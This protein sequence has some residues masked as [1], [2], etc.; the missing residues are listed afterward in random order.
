METH[1]DIPN[2][3]G[4]VFLFHVSLNSQVAAPA[5]IDIIKANQIL[6]DGSTIVSSGGHFELGFVSVGSSTNQYVGIWYKKISQKTIVWIANRET[7]LSATSGLLKLNSN[8]NLVILNASDDVVWSSNSSTSL[9]DP[10]LQLLDS[11]NLVIRDGTDS[12]PDHFLW[13]SFDKPG[14]TQLP[15]AKIGWNFETGFERYLTSWKNEDDPSPGIYTNRVTRNGFPQ[16][17]VRKGSDIFTRG[18]SWNGVR[19]SGT[20]NFNPNQIFTSDFV[21]NDKELYYR[22]EVVNSSVVMRKIVNSFGYIQRL[23]WIEKTQT[24]QIY[25]SAPI[26]NCD[27]YGVCGAYGSCNVNDS[28]VCKCFNGF[29]PKDKK[30]WDATDW[31]SGCARKVPLSCANGEGFVKHSGLKLPDTQRSWFDTNMALMNVR[32]HA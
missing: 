10:V 16:L 7:P 26:D 4:N 3:D 20:P 25:F 9:N 8:G 27:R 28:P 5:A 11:G 22:Y 32:E 24:W 31:S 12:D 30:E 2:D 17:I 29:Q 15:G 21:S 23:V 13:Q 18:G 19:F 1:V 14:N 6:R